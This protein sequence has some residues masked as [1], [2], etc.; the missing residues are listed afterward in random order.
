[1]AETAPSDSRG[2]SLSGPGQMGTYGIGNQWQG[3]TYA[4]QGGQQAPQGQEFGGWAYGHAT[5]QQSGQQQPGHIY[6]HPEAT[7][8]LYYP[9][10]SHGG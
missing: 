9:N 1:M 7:G 2:G 4:K 10:T 8:G 6:A 3:Y 5:Q